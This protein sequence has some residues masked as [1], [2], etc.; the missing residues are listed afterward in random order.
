WFWSDRAVRRLFK[1]SGMENL[2]AA[3]KE[4]RG[5]MLIGVHFMSLE[6]GGRISG[7]CQPMMAM[8]RPH[9]NQAMEYVQTKGRMRSN[10]AMIDRRDLRGMVNA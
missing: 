10:K 4:K 5:V 9:N 7:L 1:V 8:Y 6:L 3:Q 2:H